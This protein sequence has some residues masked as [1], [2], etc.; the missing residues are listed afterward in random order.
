LSSGEEEE[1]KGMAPSAAATAK[2]PRE[3]VQELLAQF[4]GDRK[5]AALAMK[6]EGFGPTEIGQAFKQATGEGISGRQWGEWKLQDKQQAEAHEVAVVVLTAEEKAFATTVAAKLHTLTEKVQSQIIDLGLYVF[7]SVTPLVP[8]ETA[9][10]KVKNT[11]LWLQAAVENFDPE[12]AEEVEKFGAAA[13][14]AA[15]TLK[16]QMN[17]LMEWADPSSRLQEMAERA[18]YSTNP[19]NE[20]AFDRLMAELMRS[21]HAAPRF[22]G[23][24]SAEEIP[25]IAEAY[26]HARGIPVE[27]ATAR[28]QSL[29][30]L[31][32]VVSN[33]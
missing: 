3:R 10:D 11:K 30:V 24:A 21:I 33:E 5:K 25:A 31:E 7:E 19:V 29:P 8:A 20:M 2:K 17:E 27:R 13:F 1:K 28:M 22:K 18:L 15:C 9:E 26:A 32:E 6:G 16:R 23:A 4:E 14:L 12:E